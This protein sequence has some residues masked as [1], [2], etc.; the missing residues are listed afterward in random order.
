MLQWSLRITAYAERLLKDLGE[1]DFSEAMKRMQSNWI[2]RSEGAQMFFDVAGSD[3]KIEI[4]TTRPDT[5]FGAT[6]MVLAPEHDLVPLLTAPDQKDSV[7][8]YLNYAKSRSERDRMAEVKEVTG[9][10]LGAYAIN[11]FTNT[12]IPIWIG[13]YVLKDYGTGAIMA[14]PSDDDRDWA[15]ATKFGLEIIDVIDKSKYPGATRHDKLGI[16]INSGPLDGMEV[17]DAIELTLRQ[18][19]ERGLGKRKVNFKLRDAIFSRQR[20]W[21]EPFPIVYDPEG[22]RIPSLTTNCRWS[23]PRRMT[24][25]RR[26]GSNLLWP[27]MKP[28]ANC[29]MAGAG[30]QIRCPGLPARPGTSS[31]IWIP[32]TTRS[33]LPNK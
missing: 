24:S 30:K 10:F 16:M 14:V 20:Y 12:E 28:G 5:I 17:P 8:S 23:C 26:P 19:E 29:L 25:N 11:P 15:F 27:G 3:L 22:W 33:L 2:G 13:D 32:A 18:I 31:G 1:V 6:Y 21:G 9:A 4:F 7:E